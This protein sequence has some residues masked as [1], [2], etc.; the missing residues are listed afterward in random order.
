MQAT[1]EPSPAMAAPEVKVD[2]VA[3]APA[4]ESA[5]MEQDTEVHIPLDK[6][7]DL[8]RDISLVQW[9]VHVAPKT[10]LDLCLRAYQTMCVAGKFQDPLV[11]RFENHALPTSFDKVLNSSCVPSWPAEVL[12][13]INTLSKILASVLALRVGHDVPMLLNTLYHLF[14]TATVFNYHFSAYTSELAPD[15]TNCFATMSDDPAGP[16]GRLVDMII[17]FAQA[18]GF[19]NLRDRVKRPGLTSSLYAALLRPFSACAPLLTR[20]CIEAYLKPVCDAAVSYLQALSG[21]ALLA[22]GKE[23]AQHES[24]G[25]IVTSC[26]ALLWRLTPADAVADR[27][28][29]SERYDMFLLTSL[30]KLL[31]C[32]SYNGAM[33]ALNELKRQFQEARKNAMSQS[34]RANECLTTKIIADWLVA[35]DVVAL[36]L[37]E[38]L[39]QAQY[40]SKVEE[41]LRFLIAERRI[42]TD[43]LTLLWKAQLGKHETIQ[44]NIFE[45]L[46]HLA[47]HMDSDHLDHL[48]SLFQQSWGGSAHSMERLL[49]FVRKL[50][51][52]DSQGKV[53]TKVLDVLWRL[54]RDRSTPHE[55][56]QLALG[57]HV[58][59][60]QLG[61]VPDKETVQESYLRLCVE[62]VLAEEWVVSALSFARLLA[63]LY[64][65]DVARAAY[66]YPAPQGAA[67]TRRAVLEELNEKYAG[68]IRKLVDLLL[69]FCGQ[70]RQSLAET[71]AAAASQMATESLEHQSL[72]F[73]LLT[74]IKYLCEFG[75]L[76]LSGPD[77]AAIWDC[78]IVHPSHPDDRDMGF[79]WFSFQAVAAAVLA[80]ELFEEKILKLSLDS[81]T[82]PA[83]DCIRVYFTEVNVA[84]SAV[85]PNGM[86]IDKSKMEGERFLWTIAINCPDDAIARSAFDICYSGVSIATGT[87]PE[88]INNAQPKLSAAHAA[89]LAV[90][91]DALTEAMGALDAARGDP[92]VH[93][94]AVVRC[95]MFMEV[96][97]HQFGNLFLHSRIF[98][99]HETS[100]RGDECIVL[101]KSCT[102]GHTDTH[103][104]IH[105]HMLL[106]ALR[107]HVAKAIQVSPAYVALSCDGILL[108][109]LKDR[110]A[111]KAL[112]VSPGAVWSYRI[113]AE[114]TIVIQPTPRIQPDWE[115]NLPGVLMAANQSMMAI[116]TQLADDEKHP[117]IRAQARSLLGLISTD[118]ALLQRL[119]SL[120]N[121][122]TMLVTNLRAEFRDKSPYQMQYIAETLYG[123][124]LPND[125]PAQAAFR[126]SFYDAGGLTF[127]RDLI[128]E[129]I[130]D[131][132]REDF[133]GVDRRA[134]LRAVLRSIKPMMTLILRAGDTAREGDIGCLDLLID[135]AWRASGSDVRHP[136]PAT[137]DS[138]TLAHDAV[139]VFCVAF[140]TCLQCRVEFVS[141]E[142]AQ[143]RL[144]D[145]L[146]LPQPLVRSTLARQLQSILFSDSTPSAPKLLSIFL[147]WLPH[148]AA[149]YPL[150]CAEYFE[151]T[152]GL[153]ARVAQPPETLPPLLDNAMQWLL[154]VA[155][156]P[157][158][159]AAVENDSLLGG[160]LSLASV[161]LGKAPDAKSVFGPKIIQAVLTEFLF[162][163]SH[164]LVKYREN[165]TEALDEQYPR[166]V[167]RVARSSAMRLLVELATHCAANASRIFD[168]V[169]VLHLSEPFNPSDIDF[170]FLP[171]IAPRR[172]GG[173]AGLKNA[174]ATCY[175]NAV[176]QQLYMQPGVRN[177]LLSVCET[178]EAAQA[179]N[180]LFQVQSSF[181]H[182]LAGLAQYYVPEGFW[183]AYRH[184]GEP[185]SVREQQDAREFFDNLI[186]QLDENL[187][188][189][190][191][192]K[193]L[194]A[195]FGGVCTDVKRIRSGC[196]HEYERD[197][198]FITLSLDVRNQSNLQTSLA[199]HIRG[200]LLEQ[201]NCDKCDAKRDCIKRVL[202]KTLP[203]VLVIQLKRFDY[204]WERSMPVKFNDFF[205]F[206]VDLDM[207]SYTLEHTRAAEQGGSA[208]PMQY[209]LAGVLVHSGQA[210]GGHYYSFARK[211]GPDG[212]I[213]DSWLK[214]DDSEVSEIESMDEVAMAHEWFGGEYTTDAWDPQLK[215]TAKKKRERW[216]NAYMLFYEKVA[217]APVEL[218]ADAR[219]LELHRPQ[220]PPGIVRAVKLHNLEFRHNQDVY[221]P[222][223]F[224]FML[225]LCHHAA[226]GCS[227]ASAD[228]CI[229]HSCA[230]I[231]IRFLTTYAMRTDR[232]VR[233]PIGD[234]VSALPDLMACAH[235]RSDFADLL[236]TTENAR[237]FLLECPSVETRNLFSV[238][239][240]TLMRLV[241]QAEPARVEALE[242]RLADIVITLVYQ[243]LQTNIK[244]C[245]SLLR[246]VQELVP[247]CHEFCRR[248]LEHRFLTYASEALGTLLTPK[249]QA[250]ELTLFHRTAWQLLSLTALPVH[251]DAS[252]NPFLPADTPAPLQYSTDLASFLESEYF[253]TAL[254]HAGST[255]VLSQMYACVCWESTAMSQRILHMLLYRLTAR[256]AGEHAALYGVL[257]LVLQLADRLHNERIT[258][259]FRADASHPHPTII[260]VL[261]RN[262]IKRP[263]RSY[264]AL[265]FIHTLMQRD[266][267]AQQLLSQP[268]APAWTWAIP[269]LRRALDKAYSSNGTNDVGNGTALER[270]ASAQDLLEALRGDDTLSPQNSDEELSPERFSDESEEESRH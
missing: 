215:T 264:L 193:L 244:H 87:T 247:L 66:P 233:A 220:P 18:N 56:V 235:G 108:P 79:R 226:S 170:D 216:W 139:L 213:Q 254:N 74:F 225:S 38:R 4:P 188:K 106:G 19:T 49:H 39:H 23:M 228:T 186:D 219:A 256:P 187:A 195:V 113:Q 93:I 255:D 5:P 78:L 240:I 141:R 83:I 75:K 207:S 98:P 258:Y 132:N 211:R 184:W 243:D 156:S 54:A 41:I 122:P 82:P 70:T 267:F 58:K 270:T 189:Q 1:G 245:L 101:V 53:A 118:S 198:L 76:N 29:V 112:G 28:A 77:T 73:E 229:V 48:F 176:I 129:A 124:I 117:T 183:K 134:F 34:L 161:L 199:Q 14:S 201:Y 249:S 250:M 242:A 103:V 99:S 131:A 2:G 110:D 251:E 44:S 96:Y 185:V 10:A 252:P 263:R 153:L 35:N 167:S 151:L 236:F 114:P 68:L 50:G 137:P 261:E 230:R 232:A 92:V 212:E 57:S 260:D 144:R 159:S 72:V 158:P 88:A 168:I 12:E 40:V 177:G 123:L 45:L 135:L 94:R 55:I 86:L 71:P 3:S 37:K 116:I 191:Y 21:P 222:D 107:I 46:A 97:I 205:E 126:T 214:F 182:M 60:L 148:V 109:H 16:Y 128:R 111:L 206:P 259:V 140:S 7:E 143:V 15:N 25:S 166:C 138:L 63:D 265:K 62:S 32:E 89:F 147:E 179:D 180:V 61:S 178:P 65:A 127:L 257:R 171:L 47:W 175:M 120:M 145:L 196:D 100:F 209:R 102:P 218:P 164:L 200:E 8:E 238:M 84:R 203:K 162:P 253:L 204:D 115:R 30:L 17:L 95:L 22:E 221:N 31:Q 227:G 90:C 155:A 43:H 104:L 165:P 190:G 9:V 202:F 239:T 172:S 80:T 136:F 181:A 146:L 266:A 130:D 142:Y 26:K 194:A 13:G 237:A 192:P 36:L 231:A 121:N 152:C 20:Q 174:C 52:D 163:S 269:W 268:L 224:N 173:L 150:T 210:S 241:R 51:E 11:I 105:M 154:R 160:Y 169:S 246:M 133:R 119:H 197:E 64:P 234:W 208:P 157:R 91:T 248:L 85:A 27:H 59:I 42:T 149:D 125:D 217:V 6:L 67:R 81:L 262:R 223:Y 69:K 33:Y 24:L